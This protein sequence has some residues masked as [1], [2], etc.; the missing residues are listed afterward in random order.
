MHGE[1]GGGRGEHWLR[2]DQKIGKRP[3]KQALTGQ[4]RNAR[5]PPT[6][7]TAKLEL[8]ILTSFDRAGQTAGG[9]GAG[10]WT[11]VGTAAAAAAVAAGAMGFSSDSPGQRDDLTA[12]AQSSRCFLPGRLKS[13][14]FPPHADSVAPCKPTKSSVVVLPARSIAGAETSLSAQSSEVASLCRSTRSPDGHARSKR[15]PRTPRRTGG[16][17]VRVRPHQSGNKSCQTD[18]TTYRTRTWRGS[19]SCS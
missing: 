12:A 7:T 2:S 14:F 8:N 1:R 18:P 16:G 10:A 13:A 3:C 5:A 17:G 9:A 15:D 6:R 4:S 19:L 11:G